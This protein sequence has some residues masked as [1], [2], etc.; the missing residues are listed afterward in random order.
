MRKRMVVPVFLALVLLGIGLL[1]AVIHDHEPAYKGYPL[2]TW[3]E[4]LGRLDLQQRVPRGLPQWTRDDIYLAVKHTGTNAF[5]YLLNWIS[6]ETRSPL[7]CR[8]PRCLN[9]AMV[10]VKPGMFSQFARQYPSG[11]NSFLVIK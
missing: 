2:R 1:L 4:V 8:R 5:P 10:I 3:V 9:S 7:D 11:R 6:D